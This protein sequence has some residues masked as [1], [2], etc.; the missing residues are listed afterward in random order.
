MTSA[1]DKDQGMAE[2]VSNVSNNKSILLA[3]TLHARFIGQG[4]KQVYGILWTDL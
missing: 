1:I 3:P 2:S 4:Y